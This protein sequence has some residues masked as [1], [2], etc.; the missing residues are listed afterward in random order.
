M[1]FASEQ[2]ADQ[3]KGVIFSGS[4]PLTRE[5]KERE[6]TIL[7]APAPMESE[8]AGGDASAPSDGTSASESL[9]QEVPE[10]QAPESGVMSE[11]DNTDEVILGIGD[12]PVG[13]S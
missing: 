5:A 11:S 6:F 12:G 10:T 8:T 4:I 2:Q 3:F 1:T 13:E 7:P 9:P